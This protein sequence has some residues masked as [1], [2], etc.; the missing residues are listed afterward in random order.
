MIQEMGVKD[1]HLIETHLGLGKKMGFHPDLQ[2]DEWVEILQILIGISQ[3]FIHTWIL[4][5]KKNSND[6][7]ITI[8]TL[9]WLNIAIEAIENGHL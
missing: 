2:W 6:I 1:K 7:F 3:K 9:W 4:R 5:Q 8:V